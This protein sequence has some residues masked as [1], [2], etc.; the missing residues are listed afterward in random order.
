MVESPFGEAAET[1]AGQSVDRWWR[2]EEFENHVS[3][4]GISL[5]AKPRFGAP[6]LVSIRVLTMAAEAVLKL[7]EEFGVDMPDQDD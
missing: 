6:P 5:H 3:A 4:E 2:P 1:Y 7:N